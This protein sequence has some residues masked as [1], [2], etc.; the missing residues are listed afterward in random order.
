[1]FQQC[2]KSL[3]RRLTDRIEAA[4]KLAKLKEGESWIILL[5]LDRTAL[6]DPSDGPFP[7]EMRPTFDQF[8]M[9][10]VAA[11]LQNLT[12]ETGN[13]VLFAV[14][15]KLSDTRQGRY[16]EV[17]G[18]FPFGRVVEKETKP[19]R[20]LA[21]DILVRVLGVDHGYDVEKWRNE[22]LRHNGHP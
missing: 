10:V 5:L 3:N 12:D 11:L 19:I 22:I 15:T 21:R 20:D 9:A 1:L 14:T 16:S 13:A 6:D 17:E 4:T 7:E 18:G 8:D 2:G